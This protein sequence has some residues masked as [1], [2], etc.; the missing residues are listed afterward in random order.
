MAT[1]RKSL[2]VDRVYYVR[3]SNMYFVTPDCFGGF[4]YETLSEAQDEHGDLRAP[5]HIEELED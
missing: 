5:I 4:W 2:Q 1:P 3:S